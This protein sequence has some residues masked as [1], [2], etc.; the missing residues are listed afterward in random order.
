MNTIYFVMAILVLV[1][2][3]IVSTMVGCEIR[4]LQNQHGS[5]WRWHFSFSSSVWG[6]FKVALQGSAAGLVPFLLAHVANAVVDAVS[7]GYITSDT[8]WLGVFF[9]LALSAVVFAIVSALRK[10]NK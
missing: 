9:L 1:Y 4:D 2:L 7:L 6:G 5:G 3:F 8:A 10:L